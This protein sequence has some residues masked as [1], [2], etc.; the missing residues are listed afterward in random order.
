MYSSAQV[1]NALMIWF[2]VGLSKEQLYNCMAC[3]ENDRK[4]Y[5][6]VNF[7]QPFDA[8]GRSDC[9]IWPNKARKRSNTATPFNGFVF[10]EIFSLRIK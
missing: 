4:F 5:I 2:D 10:E 9:T 1:V 6:K 7:D 3:V 8:S